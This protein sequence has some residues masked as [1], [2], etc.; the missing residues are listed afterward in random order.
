MDKLVAEILSFAKSVWST[1]SNVI[2]W[3]LSFVPDWTGLSGFGKSRLIRS[4]YFW[5]PI[6][7]LCAR[8]FR[9]VEDIHPKIFGHT[10]DLKIGLPFSWQLFFWAAVCFGC[11]SVVY[12][13][14]CPSIIKRF[15]SAAA[16]LEDSNGFRTLHFLTIPLLSKQFV[17]LSN[18]RILPTRTWCS[19]FAAKYYLV[20][21]SLSS[22]DDSSFR[23]YFRDANMNHT[24]GTTTH[25]ADKEGKIPEA[26]P[27]VVQ[28]ANFSCLTARTIC[29]LLYA[30]A[31]V[32]LA[33]VVYKNC[34]YVAF[35]YPN[36]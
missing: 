27:E 16:F 1:F 28:I 22:W 3:I 24:G 6:V 25:S 21:N 18:T 30:T 26:F 36:R 7:P 15:R 14:F 19:N 33:I 29:T 4:S 17:R 34:Y 20:I 13:G 9:Q 10:F 32:L 8:M 5:I 2:W 35:Q 11:A 31:L 23:D 12:S